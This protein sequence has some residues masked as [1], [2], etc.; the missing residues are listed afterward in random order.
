MQDGILILGDD[1][2][3]LYALGA[4]GDIVWQSSTGDSAG[5]VV[6][7]SLWGRPLIIWGRGRR[8]KIFARSFFS[9]RASG[10][11]ASTP[12]SPKKTKQPVLS[13]QKR[14]KFS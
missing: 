9:R 1:S 5:K 12:P 2:G 7:I 14:V 10:F 11:N 8:V 4:N 3:S 13:Q 6:R